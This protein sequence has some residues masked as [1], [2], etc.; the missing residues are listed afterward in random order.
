MCKHAQTEC[1]MD[2][3]GPFMA[4]GD[5]AGMHAYICGEPSQL[6]TSACDE[7]ALAVIAEE[8][9]ALCSGDGDDR[10]DEC[11]CMGGS[12][13]DESYDYCQ[14]SGCPASMGCSVPDGGSTVHP[15]TGRR[16]MQGDSVE[17]VIRDLTMICPE[18]M[19]NCLASESCMDGLNRAIANDDEAPPTEGSEELMALVDCV[20]A[21]EDGRGGGGSGGGGSGHVVEDRVCTHTTHRCMCGD[22]F[23]DGGGLRSD[24]WHHDGCC[25][26]GHGTCSSHQ[27]ASVLYGWADV[28]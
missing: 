25:N 14:T 21:F 16:R 23:R 26:S 19:E 2:Q 6:D 12:C 20:E 24:R 3:L 5:E 8:V 10:G 1:I 13:M 15:G 18:E 17:E 22:P 7:A 27:P 4:G 11:V 28:D 9:P